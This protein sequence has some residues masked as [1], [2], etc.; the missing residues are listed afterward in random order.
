MSQIPKDCKY[1]EEHEWV[2][3]E[4][5]IAT[6]GITDYAQGELGDVV[7]LEL[8]EEG[9]ILKLGEAFGSIEAVKTVA[10]LYS[11]VSGEVVGVNSELEDTP[12]NVN[13]DPFGE[14][15]LIKIKISDSAELDGLMDASAYEQHIA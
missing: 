11:P 8:P 5:D 1:T 12:E 2:K 14:G 15:W 6:M 4:G 13:Q 3:M 7:F 9:D 10:D